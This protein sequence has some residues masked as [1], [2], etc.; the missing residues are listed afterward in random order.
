MNLI[1]DASNIIHRAFWMAGKA[2]DGE[3]NGS[4]HAFIFLKCLKSYADMFKPH[5]IYCV[6][7][8][9]INPDAKNFR[10]ELYPQYKQTRDK[11]K[12]EK[13]Y[14][15]F[16][17]IRELIVSLGCINVFPYALEGDDV[18]AFLTRNLEEQKIII[19]AD[20]D[21][22]QLISNSV[23]F[24]DV[25]K[26]HTVNRGNFE[27]LIGIEHDKFLI[28]KC[29]TGDAADNIPKILTPAKLKKYYEGML[30]LSEEQNEQ[31]HINLRLMNLA[32]ASVDQPEEE[33]HMQ[34]QLKQVHQESKQSFSKFIE[35]CEKHNM[36]DI[37]RVRHSWQQ[38]FFT[39]NTLFSIINSLKHK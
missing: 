18:I 13:V 5:K 34:E 23:S 15:D 2:E 29:L 10:S 26:K 9:R 28:N 24:Y 25:N 33:E 6:W 8:D 31:L 19:S 38:T 20:K 32:S 12:R 14:T 4:L 36:K 22:L 3:T 1:I 11:E 21:L 17:I 27:Q 35:M 37:L 30:K 7:D 39:K 16:N